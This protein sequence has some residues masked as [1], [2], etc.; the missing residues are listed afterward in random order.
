MLMT[1][2]C[3][4]ELFGG[5]RLVQQDR[6]LTRFRTQ[7]AA[8]LLAYLALN[9]QQ[10][11]AR[12]QLLELFWPEMP[13]DTARGNLRTTLNSLRNQLEPPGVAA[14][15]VLIADR[16]AVRLNPSAVSTDVAEF[17]RMSA[18][19]ARTEDLEE[20]ITHLEQA[21]ALYK[22]DLLP[23]LYDDWALREQHRCRSLY[24]DAL[25]RLAAALERSGAAER[26]LD[27]ARRLVHE[28]PG[29]EEGCRLQMRLYVEL[30]RP[31]A[32]LECYQTLERYL[33]A[34]LGVSPER[35][36]RQLAELFRGGSPDTESP[37]PANNGM[38]ST[39]PTSKPQR[40]AA[41]TAPTTLPVAPVPMAP[42]L[43]LQLTRY[44]GRETQKSW[45][46]E[47]LTAS[48]TR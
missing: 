16:Q 6:A 32:A 17:D 11:H 36:T 34:E 30:G 45:L 15:S 35:E 44:V 46:S 48:P 24:L 41:T 23:S 14:G 7:K 1:Q 26:A 5:L 42:S 33:Q 43:P 39:P 13:P 19:A 2:R 28:E 21:T 27:A 37:S 20:R 8:A 10:T 38:P 4:I 9:L 47:N 18:L 25:R 3:R 12:E 22:A 29:D 31:A 40:P